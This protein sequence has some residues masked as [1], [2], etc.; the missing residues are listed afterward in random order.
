MLISIIIIILF[1]SLTVFG[2]FFN[3]LGSILNWF[4][5]L[6]RRSGKTGNG[7]DGNSS[8]DDRTPRQTM[9]SQSRRKR[10]VIDSDDGEYVDFEEVK[11]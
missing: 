7:N 9:H 3:V 5:G 10:K 1:V 2:L 4:L 6:F 11:R 8:Y